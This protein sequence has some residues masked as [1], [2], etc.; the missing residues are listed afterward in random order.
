MPFAHPDSSLHPSFALWRPEGNMV[1]AQAILEDLRSELKIESNGHPF[2]PLK[3]F[4]KLVVVISGE[5]WMDYLK[6]KELIRKKERKVTAVF[7]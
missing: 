2:S 6:V 3:R 5:R 4:S 7:I 1:R